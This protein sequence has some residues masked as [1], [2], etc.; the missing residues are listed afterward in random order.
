MRCGAPAPARTILRGEHGSSCQQSAIAVSRSPRPLQ[1]RDVRDAADRL[2]RD[3]YTR[4]AFASGSVGPCL[5]QEIRVFSSL[6]TA[7]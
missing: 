3:D 7:Q 2:R 5:C 4:T 1:D 6:G